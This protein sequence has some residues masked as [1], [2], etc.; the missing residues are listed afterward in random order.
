MLIDSRE[1]RSQEL[2]SIMT[3]QNLLHVVAAHNTELVFNKT[4]MYSAMIVPILNDDVNWKM[5]MDAR[6]YSAREE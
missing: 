6:A 5:V 1:F 4:D 3:F 2:D